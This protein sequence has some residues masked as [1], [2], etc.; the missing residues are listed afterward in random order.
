MFTPY[1]SAYVPL[2]KSDIAILTDSAPLPMPCIPPMKTSVSLTDKANIKIKR[3]KNHTCPVTSL[4]SKLNICLILFTISILIININF[5][6]K[7]RLQSV[8][9]FSTSIFSLFNKFP[10]SSPKTIITLNYKICETKNKILN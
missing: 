4:A 2:L 7:N 1:A 6:D 5:A 9:N 8:S 10:A 3:T